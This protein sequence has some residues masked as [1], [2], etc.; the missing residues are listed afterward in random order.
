MASTKYL[1]ELIDTLQGTPKS[2]EEGI[3]FIEVYGEG[4]PEIVDIEQ[5]TQDDFLYID[6]HIFLCEV[7]GWWCETGDFAEDEFGDYVD[8]VCSDHTGEV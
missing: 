5:L 1:D 6:D 2:I 3:S 8:F 4:T 7:C